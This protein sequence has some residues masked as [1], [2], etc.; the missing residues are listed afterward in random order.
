MKRMTTLTILTLLAILFT[1]AL[2]TARH[3]A[4][5][6]GVPVAP[7]TEDE[8]KLAERL[9]GH[10]TRLAE[11][12][13]E[14]N[15]WRYPQL[16]AAALYIE[17]ELESGGFT[18]K[19][20]TYTAYDKE[21]R[22]LIVEI[23]GSE[24]PEEILLVGAHYD[25]VTG[26]PGANDNA[27]GVA[28]LLELARQLAGTHPVRTVRLVAFVNEEPPFFK[29]KNMGSMVYVGGARDRGE[30]I[31]AMLCLETLG[32][33]SQMKKSQQFPL[34]L[35]R[36]YYPN[37]G[38]FLTFVTNVS[39]RQLLRRSLKAFRKGSNFPAEGLVAPGWLPGVDWSDHWSFWQ[40]DVPAI[41]LTDS[42]LYRYHHYHSRQD[43]AEKLSYPEFARAVAGIIRMVE[44]LSNE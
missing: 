37:T 6:A 18:V 36:L 29:S 14:R 1:T 33:Y 20:Q 42:A 5:Q 17:A 25:S 22:N 13:G 27:S 32:Y 34:P 3:R 39:S 7:L 4:T 26:S 15:L 44:E 2:Y 41:M 30:K 43:K 31:V 12:I 19:D 28:A 21:S 10:V 38:N 40:I 11:T 24:R 9:R 8:Q 16:E 35:M 23:P